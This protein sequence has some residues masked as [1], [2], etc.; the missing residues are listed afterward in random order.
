MA[1]VYVVSDYGVLG[2]ADENLV[3]TM[4]DGG[5]TI[6]PTAMTKQL[7]IIGQI[8]IT[9]PALRLLQRYRLRTSFISKNGFFNGALE[10]GP[11]KNVLMRKVQFFKL[12]DEAWKSDFVRAIVGGKLRNQL[13]FI[14]RIKRSGRADADV[15]RVILS[16]K[17]YILQLEH[18]TDIAVMRGLEG[19]GAKDYFSVFK[20]NLLSEKAVFR[21]RTTRPPEDPVNAV[22]SFLYTLLYQRVETTLLAEGLDPA[23]GY[24][25]VP[26]YGA[27]SLAFDLMEEFRVP[28]V[29]TLTCALFNLGM[30]DT[31][32]FREVSFEPKSDENP[33]PDEGEETPTFVAR[34]GVLLTA[35]GLRKVIE[36]FEKKIHERKQY[37]GLAQSVSWSRII[38]E[39]VLQ[40]R[41]V[42]NGE[43][44][45]YQP[46]LHG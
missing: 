28:V 32:H 11:G 43:A 12:E 37:P 13:A 6:I 38:R 40:F 19:I 1:T 17:R 24:L 35:D 3:F 34:K 16:M 25:H 20:H 36:Q 10:F 7:A 2:K 41:R 21:G 18:E 8:T 26:T 14:Q 5:R 42:L 23:V 9:G 15:Q 39:Q 30:L 46:F 29:D 22:L 31:I 33:L 45:Q 44:V 27:Q 4:K